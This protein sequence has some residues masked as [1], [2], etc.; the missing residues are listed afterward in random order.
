[1]LCAGNEPGFVA[2]FLGALAAEWQVFP[3][4][5][6][7]PAAELQSLALTAGATAVIGN[8]PA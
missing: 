8:G 3:V 4:S 2:A 6:Q 7:S 1:M 5:R